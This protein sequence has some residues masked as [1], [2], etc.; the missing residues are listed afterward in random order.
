MR[1]LPLAVARGA[2]GWALLWPTL[3]A[4][5]PV[6]G[7]SAVLCNIALC[8]SIPVCILQFVKEYFPSWYHFI[9]YWNNF[10]D[11]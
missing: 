9:T 11:F 2:F 5:F 7:S 4:S 1:T 8:G 3:L 6:R 10:L